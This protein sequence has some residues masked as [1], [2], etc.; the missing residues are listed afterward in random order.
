MNRKLTRR[1]I[2]KLLAAAPAALAAE[3]RAQS[4][5]AGPRPSTTTAASDK[6]QKAVAKASADLKKGLAALHKTPIPIGT[7]PATVF[8]ALTG[9]K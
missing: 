3:A 8:S 6:R 1:A 4:A 7:E 5:T 9:K 2:A